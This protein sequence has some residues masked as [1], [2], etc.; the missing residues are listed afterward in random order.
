MAKGIFAHR[1]DSR[2]NDEL[3]KQ[4]HFPK[5]YKSRVDQ[6]VGDWIA[7]YLPR[8]GQSG[9]ADTLGYHAAAIVSR[10]RPDPD[11]ADHYYADIEPGSFMEF[12]NFVPYF[13]GGAFLET[14]L[15]TGSKKP[16]GLI[17]SAVRV[18]SDEDFYRIFYRGNPLLDDELP[19]DFEYDNITSPRGMQEGPEPFVFE[20]DRQRFD[21]LVSRPVRDRIFRNRVVRAY[22]K[23]CAFT[24]L[25]FINGGGRAEVQAAHIRPVEKGGPDLI[26]NGLALSGTVHWMF[27]RG[28][29]SLADNYDIMV[30]RQVNNPDDIWRLMSPARKAT[31]PERED[32]RPHPRFLQWHREHCFKA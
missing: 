28:L 4:Y 22:D 18:I 25:R 13:D 10:V 20:V 16:S 6:L 15:N 21:H 9:T 17:R 30:S 2:Y 27:D 7:Y 24:G 1:P 31:V 23:R 12:E 32:L 3:D 26:N 29:I 8:G 14:G 19:R 11:M 5:N